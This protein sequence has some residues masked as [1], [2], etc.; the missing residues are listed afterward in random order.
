V[1]LGSLVIQG[2]TLRPLILA[3]GLNDE[4]PVAIETARARAIAY[5]AALAE[6]EADPSEEAEILRLEYRALLLRAGDDPNGGV[7]SGELPADPLRRRAIGAARQSILTLRQSEEIGDDAFHQLE[8]EFDRAE[9]S[10]QG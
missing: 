4:D 9:L 6:I 8:E 1:V 2:L 7:V 3:L 10:A 5:R